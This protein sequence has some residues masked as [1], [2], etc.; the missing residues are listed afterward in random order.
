[1][2]QSRVDSGCCRLRIAV[3]Q[4]L[5][6]PLILRLSLAAFTQKPKITGENKCA[7]FSLQGRGGGQ[8]R[9]AVSMVVRGLGTFS[10]PQH[11]FHSQGCLVVSVAA[12][13]SLLVAGRRRAG[14]HRV[15]L[16]V[17]RLPFGTFQEGL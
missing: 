5:C 14:G 13:F 12:A 9:D 11:S 10:C 17:R 3:N 15:H 7:S 16:L 6:F 4:L 1:M 2:Y 8:C